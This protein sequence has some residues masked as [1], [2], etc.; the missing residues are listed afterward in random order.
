[1]IDVPILLGVLWDWHVIPMSR[2]S[3]NKDEV[4][5]GI[6]FS[7]REIGMNRKTDLHHHSTLDGEGWC[8]SVSRYSFLL[9]MEKMVFLLGGYQRH[10]HGL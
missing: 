2:G 10:G 8:I 9:V 7:P 3:G 4:D 5:T 6:A 1:M